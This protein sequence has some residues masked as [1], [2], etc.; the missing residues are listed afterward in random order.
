MQN[1]FLKLIQLISFTI[2][3]CYKMERVKI[4]QGY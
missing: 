1:L 2:K 4:A 3:N